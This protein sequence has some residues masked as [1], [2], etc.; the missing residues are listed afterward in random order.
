MSVRKV[1]KE[2]GFS[3]TGDCGR[4]GGSTSDRHL[5]AH[6]SGVAGARAEELR[7]PVPWESHVMQCWGGRNHGQ[8]RPQRLVVTG[9]MINQHTTSSCSERSRS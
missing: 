4:W 2:F 5:S 8:G 1:T 3:P 7:R 9:Q 6:L